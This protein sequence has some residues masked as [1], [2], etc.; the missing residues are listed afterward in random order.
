MQESAQLYLDN[1][2]NSL[3]ESKREKYTSF[4]SDYFCA[5]EKNA[6]LCAELIRTGQKTATCSLYAGYELEEEPM[7]TVGHLLVVVDWSAKP[8]CIVEI[9]SVEMCQY[10]QVSAE[11]AFAEGE[12]DRTLEWWREA[13]W[14]FFTW[15]SKEL[16]IEPKEDMMLVLERFHLVHQ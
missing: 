2:L 10:N 1:Y 6:N 13:H 15:H 5:D 8:I 4:S 9:D 12:G 3:S 16:G 11:F 7:P 14:D